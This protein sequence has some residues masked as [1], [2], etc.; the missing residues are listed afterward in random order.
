MEAIIVMIKKKVYN[1]EIKLY[2]VKG[3]LVMYHLIYTDDVLIFHCVEKGSLNCLKKT[4]AAFGGLTVLH[5][6][7]EKSPL[8]LSQAPVKKDLPKLRGELGDYY[9]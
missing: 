8:Y 1:G 9:M 2:E 7:K 3:T 4:L 5:L 6:S